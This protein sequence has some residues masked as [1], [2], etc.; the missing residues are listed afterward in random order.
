M[1]NEG[2]PQPGAN[3]NREEPYVPGY[4]PAQIQRHLSRTVASEAAFFLPHLRSGMTLLDC[5]CGPGTITVGLAQAVTPGQVV[6]VDIEAGVVERASALA[7]EQG[8]SNVQFQVANVYEL[9]FSDGSF[10]AVFA[11]TLLH[12]L[13]QPLRAI[14]EMKRV[15]KSGG[16][17]GI[18]DDDDGGLII[19]PAN[20]GWEDWY[21]LRDKM[22]KHY[23]RDRRFGRH[24]RRLLREAGFGHIEAS[25]SYEWYG[26]PEA[27]RELAQSRITRIEGSTAISDAIKA[28]LVDRDTLDRMVAELRRW[29][30]DP[31][32]FFANPRCEAVA[33][34]E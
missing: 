2:Q 12:H 6:G 22:W 26:T 19:A 8:L 23:G 32:A 13:N 11:H 17:I 18:R 27:T 34:K 10:D 21:T 30:E 24:L 31:D 3:P 14:K 29:G 15:L 1:T 25:A 4:R 7:T 9:T 33:W 28:G 20:Q 5:G 16:V